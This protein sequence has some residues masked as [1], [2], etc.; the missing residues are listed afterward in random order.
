MQVPMYRQNRNAIETIAG[1]NI[2]V[3]WSTSSKMEGP[4]S[5]QHQDPRGV[6]RS[7]IESTVRGVGN[8]GANI[9]SLLCVGY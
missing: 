5:S 4:H 3:F 9:T 6:W 2:A 1:G 7:H 8:H